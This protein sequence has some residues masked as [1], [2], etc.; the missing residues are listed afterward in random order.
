MSGIFALFLVLAPQTA[1]AGIFSGFTATASADSSIPNDPSIGI[2]SQQM[3]LSAPKIGPGVLDDSDD[4]SSIQDNIIADNVL[5]P[6]LGPVGNIVTNDSYT[7]GGGD[8][9]SYTVHAGDT[10]SSVAKMFNLKNSTII[11]NNSLVAGQALK[12]GTILTILPTDGYL[13]TVAKGDTLK[14]IAAKYKVDQNSIAF[15]NDVGAEDIL[16]VGDTLIVPDATFA[17]TP[18]K[19]VTPSGGFIKRII[20]PIFTH[21]GW[22]DLGSYFSR[23]LARGVGIRTQGLHGLRHSGVDLG[24]PVGT[25]IY[26]A[27]SGVVIV[28]LTSGY[29]TGYGK[30]VQI[31]HNIP[32]YEDH[33][34]NTVY[35]HMSKVFVSPG[36]TVSR[37][38]IIG[39]V[40]NTGR[41]T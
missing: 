35:A 10:I 1:S 5:V 29:N 14:R 33:D 28:A 13:H 3:P 34:I 15:Y 4:S 20:L 21:V 18:S 37:G 41:S 16:A 6:A 19:K 32:G 39:L 8:I 30:Y 26:A 40:G 27:A 31:E 12:A 17:P 2:N 9:T 38:Q 7:D 23:P 36:Q 25:P 24:S 22:P 11:N